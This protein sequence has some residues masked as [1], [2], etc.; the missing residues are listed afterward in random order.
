MEKDGFDLQFVFV[1]CVPLGEM[2]EL[3]GQVETVVDVLGGHEILGHFDAI[4]QV[5][6]LVRG[7]RWNEHR[8]PSA[9]DY[10]VT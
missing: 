3:L 10:R 8:V 6:H 1:V 5:S 2:T 7:T 4:V 9:L